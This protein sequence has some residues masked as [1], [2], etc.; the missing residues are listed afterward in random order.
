MRFATLLIQMFSMRRAIS[1][2]PGRIARSSG[3]SSRGLAAVRLTRA[4]DDSPQPITYDAVPGLMLLPE[5][6]NCDQEGGRHQPHDLRGGT[7]LTGRQSVF[8]FLAHTRTPLWHP[9]EGW[10]QY[11]LA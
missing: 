7:D 11:R 4:H 6:L 9:E 2:I 8:V 10:R 3:V 1:I 5:F